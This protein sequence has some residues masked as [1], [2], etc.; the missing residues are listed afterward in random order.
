MS[1]NWA[2]VQTIHSFTHCLDFHAVPTMCQALAGT[3][4]VRHIFLHLRRAPGAGRPARAWERR[5]VRS[6]REKVREDF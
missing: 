5:Y 1:T 2:F 4:E 3:A 6:G